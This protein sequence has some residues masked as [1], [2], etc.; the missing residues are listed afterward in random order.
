MRLSAFIWQP[1][2]K[3]LMAA[4]QPAPFVNPD[5]VF[6]PAQQDDLFTPSFP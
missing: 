3:D 1:S 6:R 4:Q 5:V 2:A